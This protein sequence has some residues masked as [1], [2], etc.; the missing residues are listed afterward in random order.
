[1]G[2]APLHNPPFAVNNME[3]RKRQ[4]VWAAALVEH[5]RSKSLGF[6][7]PWSLKKKKRQPRRTFLNLRCTSALWKEQLTRGQG[8]AT[9]EWQ[10]SAKGSVG[11]S[12]WG[13]HDRLP[14]RD[15]LW[16]EAWKAAETGWSFLNN[17]KHINR[18]HPTQ[19]ISEQGLEKKI[20]KKENEAKRGK[21]Q[22]DWCPWVWSHVKSRETGH[23]QDS[24]MFF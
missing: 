13:S 14:E 2:G 15:Q 23:L 17:G 16:L 18:P 4:P 8:K 1:M 10:S 20:K 9:E 3:K 21:S 7:S 19:S 5:H 22:G 11:A 6:S 12:S 24:N